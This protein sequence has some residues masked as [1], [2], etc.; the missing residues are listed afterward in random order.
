MMLQRNGSAQQQGQT[1][2]YQRYVVPGIQNLG[3]TCFF[4]AILQ[5]LASVSSFQEYLDEVVRQSALKAHVRHIPFTNA[6]HD[7]IEGTC[8]C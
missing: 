3:N 8:L 4:N 7:C 2:E 6:L 5:A 1:D